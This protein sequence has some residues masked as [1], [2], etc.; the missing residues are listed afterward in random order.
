MG[1]AF[2]L[3]LTVVQRGVGFVRGM[4][5]CRLLPEDQ[6]GQWSIVWS[7]L[8]LLAPLA[9]LGLP[10]SF[11]R[12]SEHYVQRGQLQA[13]LRRVACVS[14]IATLLL[15]MAMCWLPETFS[16][17]IFRQRDQVALVR[18]IACS[19]VAVTLFNAVQSLMESLRQIRSVTLMR[20]I[21][22]VSFA[23]IAVGLLAVW[24]NSALAI[25]VGFGISCLL[26]LIPAAIFFWR[27]SE[28]IRESNTALPHSTMW[29]KIAPFAAWT[30]LSN[31]L[32]N[33]YESIDRFM[34]LHLS[35]DS[36]TMAQGTLGQYHSSL[37]VPQLLTSLAVIISGT[38]L[39]Y[40]SACW[41]QGHPDE[42]KR[43]L[44]WT[45]KAMGLGFLGVNLGILIGAPCCL[46]GYCKANMP[47]GYQF[48]R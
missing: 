31:I 29:S 19:F 43:I 13:Y 32:T 21:S 25:V 37:V 27:R 14:G 6:L 47:P 24:N 45:L 41:E 10:G 12:Y 42:A 36:P 26:G 3:L 38:V 46:I 2:A 5:F 30:W 34:L 33:S 20:F 11:C 28:F 16:Q 40:L 48:C 23:F 18:L 22:G 39:P 15:A 17:W 44:R 9:S 1:V 4:L 7:L 8:L 35:T